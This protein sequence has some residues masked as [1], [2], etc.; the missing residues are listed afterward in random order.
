[1]QQ[2]CS[3]MCKG[4]LLLSKSSSPHLPFPFT[5]QRLAFREMTETERV[6]NHYDGLI[7]PPTVSS[8]IE[9]LK[10]FEVR[11]QDCWILTYPKA[12]TRH[13]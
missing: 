11:D 5:D 8:V 9:D 10:T 7:L 6:L 13:Y 12:G 4:M 3:C 2:Q 1:M